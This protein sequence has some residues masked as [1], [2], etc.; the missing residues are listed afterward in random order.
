MSIII[1]LLIEQYLQGICSK[2]SNVV[3]NFF[4]VRWFK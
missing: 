4:Y 1:Y 3:R 2:Q